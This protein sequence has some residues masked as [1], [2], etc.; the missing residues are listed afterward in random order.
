MIAC[1][2]FYS[3]FVETLDGISQNRLSF[4]RHIA[5]VVLVE[6]MSIHTINSGCIEINV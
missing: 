1:A 4:T 2:K 5:T 3:E 6:I